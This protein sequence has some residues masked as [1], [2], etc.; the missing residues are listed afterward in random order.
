[1][2]VC[3]FVSW[4]RYTGPGQSGGRRQS[5]IRRTGHTKGLN[6]TSRVSLSWGIKNLAAYITTHITST[7]ADP[8]GLGEVAADRQ[9][10]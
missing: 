7:V 3:V 10:T 5:G 9:T 2:F 8:K 1:M 6:I 4:H